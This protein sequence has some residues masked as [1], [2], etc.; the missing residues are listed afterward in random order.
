MVGVKKPRPKKRKIGRAL[1]PEEVNAILEQCDG[2]LRIMFLTALLTGMRRGELFA[3]HW[4]DID[5]D[6]NVVKV[7]RSLFWN[8]SKH[9]PKVEG[10]PRYMFVVPKSD[11]STRD[12]DLSPALRKELLELYLQSS[13]TGL[14]FRSSK[15]T[16]LNP[17]NFTK[18]VFEKAIEAAKV[19][20][21]GWHDCRRSFGSYKLD[22]G[23]NI[24]YVMR[25]MG[26]SSVQ[27]TIDIYAH[28]LKDR[29][30]EAAAK[31]D[32]LVFGG[33]VK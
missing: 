15:G 29:N 3:L 25:Q 6:A 19:G 31:T 16:P 26:H 1:K 32:E 20:K 22:Q 4:E 13:K 2:R 10:Q 11:N 8:H 7:R 30:P 28:K 12:I 14:V 21:V 5:W 33:S 9:L 24:Y 23:E 27:V 17:D 18:R